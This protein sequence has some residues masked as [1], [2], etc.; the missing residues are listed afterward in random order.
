MSFEK[1]VEIAKKRG[2]FYPSS[3]IHGAIAGFWN[4]GVVGTLLKK[5]IENEWRNFFIK[6]EGF[7]EIEGTNIMPEKV[8]IASGHLKSF[9]DPIVQCKKCKSLYRADKLIEEK[10][11][12]FVPERA[13]IEEFNKIIKEKNIKCPKC[14][15][16]LSEV[17]FFNMMIKVNIG[18]TEES[19][20]AYLRPETCQAIFVDFLNVYRS[21]R[22]KLPFGIAQIGRSFRNEISPRQTL[23]RQREFTQAEVEIFFNPK[24]ENFPDEKFNKIKDYKVNVLSNEKLSKLSGEEIFKITKSKLIAYYLVRLFQFINTLGIP[25]ENIRLREQTQDERPFYAKYAYDCE[26]KTQIGWIEIVANHYRSDYDLSSHMKI[27]KKDLSIVENKEKLIPHV[28]EISQGIDRTLLCVMLLHYHDASQRGWEWFSFPPR[29]A[30]YTAGVFP[31]VSKDNLPQKA[32]EVF[33]IL[34]D[35]FDAFYDESGSIGRRYARA[36][37]I[38]TP[39]GITIDYQTLEDNTVTL[40]N[41][42]TTKQVRIKIEKLPEVI[43]KLLNE[44]IKFEDL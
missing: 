15:G 44:E 30:P 25:V 13:S 40:R 3:E 4:Y 38:G 22:A 27:S 1:V 11:G 7:Y 6:K 14:N 31:L 19:D 29:I 5:K 23:M 43:K 24:N 34:K 37:E 16:E 33:E 21:A 12:I 39:F 10:T 36:D 20:I 26:V 41:R 2:F 28:W 35:H 8:F 18:P 42:D 17:K 32:K 9:S